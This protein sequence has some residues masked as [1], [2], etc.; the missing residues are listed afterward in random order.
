MG[1]VWYLLGVLSGMLLLVV[2]SCAVV[3]GKISREE[4]A[5][6]FAFDEKEE[7]KD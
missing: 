5:A 3:S 7:K 4:E 1:I 2:L 6:D